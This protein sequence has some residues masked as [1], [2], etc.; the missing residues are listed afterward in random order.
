MNLAYKNRLKTL[1]PALVLLAGMT[2]ALVLAT[3]ES[4][5]LQAQNTPPPTVQIVIA[6]PQRL[7]MPV[8][9]QGVLLPVH[10]ID[11]TAQVQGRIE[12]LHESFVVGGR[13]KSGDVL[14]SMAPAEYDLAIVRSEA[15]L[16]EARRTLAAEK[17][18]VQQ[19]QNEWQVLGEG[20]PTALSLHEPQLQE[21]KAKLKLAEAELANAKLQRGYCEIR[22]PF[23][24][25]VKEKLT[26][27][28]QMAEIGKTLGRI[29]AGDAAEIRLPLTQAQ[30]AY[31]PV[32]ELGN[33]RTVGP[34]VMLSA[35]H[36]VNTVRRQ[37]VI[38]RREGIVDQSTGL[39]YW[40][41][42]LEHPEQAPPLLP[43]TFLSA[44]I[45]GR[46]LD[47]IF[48]LPRGALN[49]AQEAMLVDADNKL[50]IKRLQVLRSDADR[51]LIGAGLSA[52][53]R[54]I[55]SGLDVPVAG[56]AVVAEP[57]KRNR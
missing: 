52:G 41:A 7:R 30:I 1:L 50:Q 15:R 22:A 35:E 24:G 31:L 51:V 55:V 29:Y 17:A 19:A 2:G 26:A 33:G 36:G 32:P 23:A 20:T 40:V 45:E 57:V 47:G 16:A 39:E 4:P 44:E 48:E 37:A 42:R 18:A 27:V 13:F 49:A 21:A 5:R 11:L 46:Q 53:D 8:Q 12:S 34:K 14:V 43:G 9:S 28:G 10:E 38:V 54:V 25:R 3:G 56:M 6:Q